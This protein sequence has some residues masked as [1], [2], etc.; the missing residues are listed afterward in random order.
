[1]KKAGGRSSLIFSPPYYLSY[2]FL[3]FRQGPLFGHTPVV[4]RG[5]GIQA[6]TLGKMTRASMLFVLLLMGR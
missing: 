5:V 2:M 3:S 6:D 4:E 1:M